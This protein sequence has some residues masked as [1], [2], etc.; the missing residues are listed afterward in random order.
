[1]AEWENVGD[2]K[3]LV[4]ET[5]KDVDRFFRAWK[6]QPKY[7]KCGAQLSKS[8]ERCPECARQRKREY[9]REYLREYRQKRRE[10]RD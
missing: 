4:L 6:D 5:G 10:I 3:L 8:Q 9:M 2:D 1:M 7:C